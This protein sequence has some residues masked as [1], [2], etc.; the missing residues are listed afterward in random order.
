M[1]LLEDKKE[2]ILD[3]FHN[4]HWSMNM[5]GKY[6]GCSRQALHQVFKTW[7]VETSKS[8][9]GWVEVNCTYCGRKYRIPRSVARKKLEAGERNFD[10]KECWN[11]WF[12]EQLS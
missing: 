5:I 12:K 7:G 3:L 4:K 1:G 2:L 6:I 10:S 11:K 9:V 8:S